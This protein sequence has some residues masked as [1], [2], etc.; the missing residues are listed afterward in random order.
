MRDVALVVDGLEQAASD[1]AKCRL[2]VEHK[3]EAL[4]S[5][6]L[7]S[8]PTQLLRKLGVEEAATCCWRTLSS[9]LSS[10]SRLEEAMPV[11]I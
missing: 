2:K 3:V 1:A 9:M 5:I 7:F 4:Q 8:K 10:C 11:N 6:A